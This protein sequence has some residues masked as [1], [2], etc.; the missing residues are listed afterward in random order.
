MKKQTNL[1]LLSIVMLSMQVLFA[2]G[3]TV[4]GTVTDAQTGEPLVGT[5]VFV[6]GAFV[7]TTTDD[8]GA[9]SLSVESG[10]T[11]MV[12]YIGYKSQEVAVSEGVGLLS[13]QLEA[14]ILKQ[15]EVVV[16]GLAS[17]V[18]RRNLAS[19][20]AKVSGDELN[21]APSQSLD[22]ALGGKFAGVHIRRNTGAPG[23]GMSVNLRGV[24]TIAGETQ[25]LYVVD[26]II[27]NNFANQSGID[28]VSAATGAG[29]ARP[30]GQPTNRIA[31]VNPSDI[32]SVEVLKGASAAAIY[33][34]KA[35]N[36]VV[37]ITTKR[38][39]AGK[40]RV[41]FTQ[42]VGS[43]NI[44]NK[45]GHRVFTQEE[46]IAQYGEDIALLGDWDT[47]SYTHLTLP[48]NREV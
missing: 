6:K 20:V 5:Q 28:V 30:Q 3:M 10:A 9:F 19:A 45:Q 27:V 41:N 17:S 29:S 1:L 44:M 26:G 34:A 13:V 15:D 32:E 33:G 46:A 43:R 24:A 14:D 48:T 37:I 35:S 25:P 16:T 18:K 4:S 47:V 39:S 42:R 36:G 21:G 11:L 12:A 38:G 7:G 31:D 22:Q 8:N 40:T 23:G 2:Q